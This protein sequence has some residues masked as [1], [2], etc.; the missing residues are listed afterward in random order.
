MAVRWV[1]EHV[2]NAA[3]SI[4]G[5][6]QLVIRQMNKVYKVKSARMVPLFN[7]LTKLLSGLAW[8]AVWVPREKN[9]QADMLANDFYRNYCIKHHGK[10]LLTMRERGAI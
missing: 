10:V 2:S 4:H 5:D 9:S 8:K 7:E 3:L 6:S 1:K